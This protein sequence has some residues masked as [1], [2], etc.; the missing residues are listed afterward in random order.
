[1]LKQLR[2]PNRAGILTCLLGAGNVDRQ[3]NQIEA[4]DEPE[5]LAMVGWPPAWRSSAPSPRGWR[6]L[7]GK[8]S[9]Q[10]KC[11]SQKSIS[12]LG[13]ATDD[14]GGLLHNVCVRTITLVPLRMANASMSA[15]PQYR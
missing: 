11:A 10:P 15:P 7:P 13:P 8:V 4:G 14:T 6:T 2:V 12:L 3:V 5:V 9:N 1:M